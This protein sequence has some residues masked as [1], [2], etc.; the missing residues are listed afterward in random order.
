MSASGARD[1][2]TLDLGIHC[3]SCGAH[4]RVPP[5][6]GVPLVHV[7]GHSVC[8][9]CDAA[10]QNTANPFCCVCKRVTDAGAPNLALA[11]FAEAQ[12]ASCGCAGSGATAAALGFAAVSE[13]QLTADDDIVD[14]RVSEGSWG[15][16][17]GAAAEVLKRRGLAAAASGPGAGSS[18]PTLC[19]RHDSC[20]LK[21]Y[22]V[23]DHQAVCSECASSLHAP[24]SHDVRSL[25]AVADQLVTSVTDFA[26]QC[27]SGA[28]D[29]DRHIAAVARAANAMEAG[30]AASVSTFVAC[31]ERV[32]SALDG[33]RDAM[34]A[35]A[36]TLRREKRK[37][38]DAQVEELTVSAAQLR[39]V[40]HACRLA[41][42]SASTL[43]VA[44][45]MECARSVRSLVSRAFVGPAVPPVLQ[46]LSSM[47]DLIAGFPS[48]S[49]VKTCNIDAERCVVRGVGLRLWAHN[50]P[51]ANVVSVACF[52]DG[53]Q[54]SVDVAADDIVLAV[55]R[56]A[57]GDAGGDGL[58]AATS[59]N[60]DAV[61]A[62][63]RCVASS[64]V[65]E[66][67]YSVQP[68]YSRNK[69]LVDVKLRSGQH[70]RGSP[71][72]AH[73]ALRNMCTADGRHVQTIPV[74]PG[75]KYGMAVS[76]D[77]R[78][79]VVGDF[80]G[81]THTLVVY[82]AASGVAVR[83]IGGP[84]RGTGPGQF[85]C[86]FKMCFAPNGNLLVAERDNNR[87]QELTVEG[88]SVRCIAVANPHP[89]CCDGKYIV[90]GNHRGVG[91]TMEVFD[92]RTG[93]LLR[94]FAVHGHAVGFLGYPEGCRITPDGEHVLVSEYSTRRVSLFTLQGHFVRHI[95][96]GE[97]GSGHMDVDF[98]GNGEIIVADAANCRLC[99]YCPEDYTLLRSWGTN[100]SQNGQ[101]RTP[102]ALA[103]SGSRLYVL[104]QN[105]NRVQVF[106]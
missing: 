66:F 1:I 59:A 6:D 105:S 88:V 3:S 29:A 102:T 39:A 91:C 21:W 68:T 101:F 50:T 63:A 33:H 81:G 7:C 104:D 44:R 43:A 28:A 92:Y 24:H 22:C 71:F 83:T 77:G 87:V 97:L 100:G 61:G 9:E 85:H 58:T 96:A 46:V 4:F 93:A 53:D 26:A 75:E 73:A 60:T 8:A 45:A 67:T 34:I 15:D 11:H 84:G 36:E 98:A 74:V 56:T 54:A 55:R 80:G 47:E 106:E 30:L 27:E 20:E 38:L 86:P 32:K 95:G 70:V 79:L 76:V 12:L 51:D 89:I 57:D 99:V 82:D 17:H 5:A 18:P 90:V 49:R 103:V 52:D 69:V 10:A 48:H 65:I 14:D 2:S 62:V 35:C 72:L 78:W 37:A 16:G 25:D 64:N 31:I 41:V 94:Q 13:S 19:S 40:A 42:A 23:T